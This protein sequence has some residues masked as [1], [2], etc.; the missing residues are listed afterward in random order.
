VIIYITHI[1]LRTALI[2]L[3]CIGLKNKQFCIFNKQYSK[4]EWYEGV[5]EIFGEMEKTPLVPS[6]K[7]RDSPEGIGTP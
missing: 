6:R 3:G 2:E 1:I 5:D 7:N 4:E